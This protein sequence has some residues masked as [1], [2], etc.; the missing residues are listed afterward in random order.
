MLFSGKFGH[1]GLLLA[2]FGLS[3]HL[4][5]AD[6]ILAIFSYVFASPYR[7]VRPFI[8]ELVE[9]G[10]QVTV[11]SA[12]N[13]FEPI[14]KAHH[15]RVPMLDRLMHGLFDFEFDSD[16][17]PSKWEEALWVSHFYR[18]S[19]QYILSDSGVQQLL[20][21]S[22]AHFDL[23]I[24]NTPHSDALCGFGIHF[25]APMIGIA[26]Y[27]SAWIVDYL[28]GNSAPSVYEPMSPLGYAYGS[29]SLLDKWHNWIYKTEEWLLERLVYL[30]PQ[31]ELYRKYFHD[32]HLSF[33]EIR[34]NFSLILVNQ[35]FSLGRARSNVPNLIEVAGM[36][37]CV[38]K[39]CKLDPMPNDIQRFM[40]EAKNGVIY[41]SMGMEIIE[42]WQPKHLKLVLLET[43]SKLKQRVLWKYDDLESLT[44]KTDNIFI[45]SLMP[46]QQILKHPNLK[47]FITHGGLL[48]IIE[49]AYY[50]VPTLGLPLYYDQFSNTQRMRIAGAGQTLDINLIN[51]EMFNGTI[52]EI[53]KNPSYA[54]NAKKMSA[55]FRDQPMSPLKTAVWWTEYTLRHKDASHMRLAENDIGFLQYYCVDIVP[56]LFGRIVLTALIVIVLIYKLLNYILA[57]VPFSLSIPL[58][59]LA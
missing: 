16:P 15:I 31:V 30:P 12:L 58:L 11:I 56:I 44:N 34:R 25:N 24:M 46:Q 50:G 52:H 6:H 3:A 57:R 14:E 45:R 53:L 39:D 5:Q 9:Q 18:A 41:F 19:V 42:E 21:N 55:R 1:A 22:S 10:Y 51:V 7:T 27:G 40:D 2:A 29:S 36:H 8:N 54:T 59:H 43:F 23:I 4:T 37:M 13:H 33:D 35:H 28:A 38:H 47:L 20:Q 17:M 48:S 26:A 49:S 32:S